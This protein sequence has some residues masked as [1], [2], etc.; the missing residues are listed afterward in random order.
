MTDTE[1][2][3][4]DAFMGARVTIYRD[5]R[6]NILARQD[7]NARVNIYIAFIS[8]IVSSSSSSL[9]LPLVALT[10]LCGL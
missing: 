8:Y 9:S 5:G 1:E 2:L 7:I 3:P 6:V 10:V 4:G